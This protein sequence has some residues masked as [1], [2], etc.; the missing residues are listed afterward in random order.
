[1]SLTAKARP[2]SVARSLHHLLGE[3][4][5]TFL[6][7]DWAAPVGRACNP[8]NR[9]KGATVLRRDWGDPETSPGKSTPDVDQIGEPRRRGFEAA[10][11]RVPADLSR[12]LPVS[13]QPGLLGPVTNHEIR[14]TQKCLRRPAVDRATKID[15]D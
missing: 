8:A 14:R 3:R 13:P 2:R 6:S 7:P 4:Y 10:W 1:M 12:T 9:S 5:L 15:T 11:L